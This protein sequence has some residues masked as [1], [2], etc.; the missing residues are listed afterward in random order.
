M[1]LKKISRWRVK[2]LSR[3]KRCNEKEI[4]GHNGVWRRDSLF[5]KERKKME[6]ENWQKKTDDHPRREKHPMLALFSAVGL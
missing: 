4:N 1:L 3:K 2:D 5:S 6:G